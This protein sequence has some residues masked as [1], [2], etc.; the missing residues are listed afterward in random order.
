MNIFAVAGDPV[1]AARMLADEHVSKMTLESGQLLS[2]AAHLDGRADDF[3]YRP[4]HELHPCVEWVR[5]CDANRA[6]LLLHACELACEHQR[7]GGEQHKTAR[8]VITHEP[9]PDGGFKLWR[10]HTP[11]VQAVDDEY[12]DKYPVRAYREYYRAAKIPSG[13]FHYTGRYPPPWLGNG[14]VEYRPTRDAGYV[15][16]IPSLFEDDTQHASIRDRTM[17][18]LRRK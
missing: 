10:E 3:H 11:F 13:S 6:W 17:R 16:V 1:T 18:D 9:V 5:E 7:R 15:P 12:M 2:T 8:D 14:T 4:T